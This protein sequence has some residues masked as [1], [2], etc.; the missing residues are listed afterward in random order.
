MTNAIR[1]RMEKME[2]YADIIDRLISYR[3]SD[4]MEC[5]RDEDDG[6]WKY[7]DYEEETWGSEFCDS[8]LKRRAV[9]DEVIALIEK[10][11]LK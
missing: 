9:Y 2:V 6:N 5:Y 1:E 4:T 7:R 8:K 3:E 11:S 10:L